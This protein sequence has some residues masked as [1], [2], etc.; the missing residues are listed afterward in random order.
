M[1]FN[2]SNL[3]YSPWWSFQGRMWEYN[4]GSDDLA[5]VEA[6][7]YFVAAAKIF[8]EYDVLRVTA[9]DGKALYAVGAN[10]TPGIE[11]VSLKKL[12]AGVTSFPT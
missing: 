8:R 9:S 4:A 2:A 12:A 6:G 1:A 5:T 3:V 10:P 11:S 7:G